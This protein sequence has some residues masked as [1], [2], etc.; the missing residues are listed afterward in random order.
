MHICVV[1]FIDLAFR[2][3]V[4][5]AIF[6][7]LWGILN[8]ILTL[9]R[10][11]RTKSVVEE[12]LLKMVQYFFLVNVTFLFCVQKEDATILLPNELILAALILILYFTGKLQNRQSRSAFFQMAGNN[13]PQIGTQFNLRAEI[14]VI[15]LAILCFVGFAFFPAYAQNP[16]SNWFYESILNIVDTPV[17]GFIFKVI[18]FF[19]L[20]SIIFKLLNG[21]SYMISGAPLISVNRQFQAGKN[22]DDKKK[23]DEDKFDDFEEVE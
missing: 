13:I 8:L 9:I 15:T 1:K 6:G 22:P 23:D 2:L 10:G 11:G 20:L 7:F 16:I 17:F 21:F 3:G 4:V 19:V 12:Y 5:F 14:I 18:G